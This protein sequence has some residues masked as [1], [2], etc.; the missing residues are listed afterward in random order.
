[1]K[2]IK[3]LIFIV[4]V[5]ILIFGI[6][7][8]LFKK[9]KAPFII[10]KV[11]SGNILQ[12]V[13]ATGT[14]KIG[15]E[16][17]LSFK[18]TGRIEKIYVK[19]G[20]EV[21]STTALAKLDTNQLSIQFQEAKAS[22][23]VAQANLDK[24]LAGPSLEEIKVS[25]TE[26]KNAQISLT[27]AQENLKNSYE[28]AL[29]TL[30]DSYLKLYNSL[31]TVDLIQRTYFN[32]TDQESIKVKETK[33]NIESTM[34]R[35][36][37]YLDIAKN[38]SKNE[39]ID[40]ALSEM[41]KSLDTTSK[42]L[43]TVRES[44][45]T[46]VYQNKVSSTDKTSLDTQR[47]NINTALTN[48]TNSQQTI[49]SMK[50]SVEATEGQL[51]KAKDN[52]ALV[53]AKPRQE[54]IDLYQ[55]QIKQAQAQIQLLENQIEDTI[56]KSPI[57]GKITKINKRI[58]EIVQPV[59][60]ESVI[61][62]L[63]VSPFQIKVDI[64]EEDIVKIN[65]GNPADI[66]LTAFPNEILKGKV[67]SIDPAEKLIEGIV[68]Y[69]VT[70]DFEEAREGIK[71]GMTADLVIKTFTKENVLIIPE[72]AIQKKDGKNIVSILRGKKIEQ[73]EIEIGLKGSNDMVEIISGL[74][75]EE[76]VVIK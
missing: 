22:L 46:P 64:Y 71:P 60:A 76:V 32:T 62:I 44:C 75:E 9:R 18:N 56:L 69:E 70:I 74:K 43:T 25:E 23:E 31:N 27:I 3:I 63:P 26:V 33:G 59:L 47:T 7:Q 50:L 16:I 39:N 65:V 21:D 28:D 34:S 10:E 57:E 48:I 29:I 5:T 6:Y 54:D 19:V 41:K 58:G 68:Y 66:T 14:V 8:G 30:D 38:D 24:L 1:M 40:I 13:S 11:I 51:Q 53:V 55:A 42:A 52:L 37:S 2:K 12:W 73:R 35:A 61:S 36:K 20:N 4:L 67:I 15:E 72:R 49:S 45:E 17:N